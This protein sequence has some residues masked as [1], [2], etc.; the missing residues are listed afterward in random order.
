ML[1]RLLI[2]LLLIPSGNCSENE[3]QKCTGG[4]SYTTEKSNWFQQAFFSYPVLS[5]AMF[6]LDSELCCAISY[7]LHAPGAVSLN[8]LYRK[9]CFGLCFV[10]LDC[11]STSNDIVIDFF[12]V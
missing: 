1:A 8:N 6:V 7:F 3:A 2:N 11:L 12:T 4:S 5:S 9:L 10:T